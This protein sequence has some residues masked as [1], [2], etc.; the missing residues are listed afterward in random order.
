MLCFGQEEEKVVITS[1]L[2]LPHSSCSIFINE[3]VLLIPNCMASFFLN[4]D[5]KVKSQAFTL[6]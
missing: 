4:K 3:V 6:L 5:A 2:T 1:N